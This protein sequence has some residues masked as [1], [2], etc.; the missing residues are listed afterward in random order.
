[1]PHEDEN[2]AHLLERRNCFTSCHFRPG[3]SLWRAARM[4]NYKLDASFRASRCKCVDADSSKLVWHKT[5]G[6]SHVFSSWIASLCAALIVEWFVFHRLS[7]GS[8]KRSDIDDL[9]KYFLMFIDQYFISRVS[10]IRAAVHHSTPLFPQNDLTS[11]KL[12]FEKRNGKIQ[13]SRR[14]H[15]I[16]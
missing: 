12:L 16:S 7:K 3:W 13:K 14:A 8:Q 15:A 4:E 9:S 1:M 2:A 10:E 11:L 5:H 6:D